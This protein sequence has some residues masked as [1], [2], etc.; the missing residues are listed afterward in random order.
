M[1]SKIKNDHLGGRFFMPIT[2]KAL[3]DNKMFYIE[4]ENDKDR[5]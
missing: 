3:F 2:F 5:E 1:I 4:S